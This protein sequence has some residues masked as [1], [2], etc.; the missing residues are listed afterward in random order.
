LKSFADKHGIPVPQPR[1]RDSLLKTV[2]EN[3][4]T[5]ANK[6][7]ETTA[8]PGDWLYSSWSDSDIKAWLDERGYPVPQ[9]STRDKLVA[10]LRRNS[11]LASLNV[12]AQ[13]ASASSSAA[14][15]SQSLTD[16]LLDAWSDSQIKEWLDKNGVKVPQGSKRNELIALARKHRARLT[17]DTAGS[18]ASSYYGA[19]TSKA[20][21]EYAQATRD[22]YARGQGAY[23][24]IWGYVEQLKGYLGLLSDDAKASA[25]SARAAASSSASSLSSV[26][27]K[28]SSSAYSAALKSGSKSGQAATDAA[29]ESAAKA[30]DKV[31]EEL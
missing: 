6:L 9:P 16:A 7:G 19:A 12:K 11:R 23:E 4:Q 27:S 14:A 15:A 13:L 20:G 2:R 22:A 31:K 26:M 24:G 30:T 18:K 17:G 25:S 3:Y 29:K 21:N 28:S 10:S 5:A 8:Y 1:T